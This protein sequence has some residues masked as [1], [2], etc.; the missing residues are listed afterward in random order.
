MAGARAE[1]QGEEKPGAG[2]APRREGEKE[3]REERRRMVSRKESELN[4]STA[5]FPS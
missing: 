3:G 2:Q 4:S 1:Q 5:I